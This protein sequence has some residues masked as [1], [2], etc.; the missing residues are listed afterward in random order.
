MKTFMANYKKIK[1]KWYLIDAKG[2]VLGRVATQAARI[3]RGKHKAIF[4]PHVDCGDGVIIINAKDIMVTGKK[5]LEKMYKS[6]SGYP[7]GLK[8][9]ALRDMLKKKPEFVLK[10]AIKG[11]LPKGS[12]GADIFRNLKVYADGEHPHKAQSPKVLEVE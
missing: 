12:L 5:M 10:H 7:G 4:T 1:K 9:I 6:Y 3:L 8:Q 2:K 11:M